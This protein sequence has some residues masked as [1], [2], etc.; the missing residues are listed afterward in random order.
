MKRMIF[1]AALI[2]LAVTGTT[3]VTSLVGVP[4]AMA[5][6]DSDGGGG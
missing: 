2:L 5:G 1:L 6:P 4:P 3:I